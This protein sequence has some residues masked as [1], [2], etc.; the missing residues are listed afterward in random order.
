MAGIL[1]FGENHGEVDM[2]GA[3]LSIFIHLVDK[4][5][6]QWPLPPV[7]RSVEIAREFLVD[8]LGGTPLAKQWP[9]FAK[10]LWQISLNSLNCVK[11]M[12]GIIMRANVVVHPELRNAL[13]YID[14]MRQ[15]MCNNPALKQPHAGYTKLEEKNHFYYILEAYEAE[16]MHKFLSLLLPACQPNSV[17]LRHDGFY[18]H[19]MPST[20]L[21]DDIAQVVAAAT[22]LT[23]RRKIKTVLP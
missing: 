5:Y 9:D 8:V 6:P 16:Y 17:V 18:I 15:R 19:P 11:H 13:V 1:L 12:T 2:V 3:H 21:L 4:H 7:L 23:A 22:G 14:Q 10:S 20:T